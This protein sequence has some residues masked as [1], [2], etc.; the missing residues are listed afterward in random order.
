MPT[1]PE[2]T[3]HIWPFFIKHTE[4]SLRLALQGSLNARPQGSRPNSCSV[5]IHHISCF[6]LPVPLP[7]SS[8]SPALHAPP[9]PP[10]PPP[11][12]HGQHLHFQDFMPQLQASC[13]VI[14]KR[15]L[16]KLKVPRNQ[17]GQRL[18]FREASQTFRGLWG[19]CLGDRVCPGQ[20]NKASQPHPI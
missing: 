1:V 14:F 12:S 4:S 3:L 10:P 13:G 6:L 5:R 20:I 7:A 8:S 11:H 16:V 9:T 15:A 17:W 18:I 19:S 2:V